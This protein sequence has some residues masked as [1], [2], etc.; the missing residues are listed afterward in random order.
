VQ[1]LRQTDLVPRPGVWKFKSLVCPEERAS[2]PAWERPAALTVG[3]RD[4]STH[5]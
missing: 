2:R 5:S 3:M 1:G 4:T